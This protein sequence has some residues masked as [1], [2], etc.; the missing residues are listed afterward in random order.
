V[1]LFWR[2]AH[3]L[4]LQD[5][6]GTIDVKELEQLMDLVGVNASEVKKTPKTLCHS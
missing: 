3:I 4:F 2:K 1:K 5:G 6:G